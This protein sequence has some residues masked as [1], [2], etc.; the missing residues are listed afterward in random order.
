MK[1]SVLSS[2]SKANSSYIEMCGQRILV[3]C[4]LSGR[5]TEERLRSVGIDPSTLNAIVVSHEHSDH[6]HGV[7]TLSRKYKI[8]VYANRGTAERLKTVYHHEEFKTGSSFWISCVEVETV[9]IT[10]DANDPVGFVFRGDGIKFPHFTD[11][12]RVTTSV[13]EA[14]MNADAM[15][16]ESNHDLE[17]L[18]SCSYSWELKQRIASTHGHLSNDTAA[19]LLKD[20]MHPGLSVVVLAHLSENSNTQE[21]TLATH[22][23]TLAGYT[24]KML[25]CGSVKAP[26]Q[27][28]DIKQEFFASAA[29]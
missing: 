27:L 2:G 7:P 22:H 10:H 20:V 6:I 23:E 17:M 21:K 1:F 8:P 29:A 3:D 25:L 12:G 14:C 28:F 24:P 5:Q 16:L 4:G 19:S 26:T 13:K 18:Q 15:V 9:S 11:L